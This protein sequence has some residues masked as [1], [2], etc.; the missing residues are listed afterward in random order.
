MLRLRPS[1]ASLHSG[2][3]LHDIVPGSGEIAARLEAALPFPIVFPAISYLLPLSGAG[4]IAAGAVA[5][6]VAG[7]GA[8]IVS[9][10]FSSKVS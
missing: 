8:V 2:S 4:A 7:A 3:T 5:A 10:R 6:G 9:G 1:S